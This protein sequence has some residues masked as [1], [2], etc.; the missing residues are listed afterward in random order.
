MLK[1][2]QRKSLIRVT[3][4][5]LEKKEKNRRAAENTSGAD[6]YHQDGKKS[7]RND[8]EALEKWNDMRNRGD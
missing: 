6:P 8:Q 3:T 4:K 7:G 2:R 1:K 5:N